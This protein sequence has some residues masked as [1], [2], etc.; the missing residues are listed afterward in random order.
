MKKNVW[1]GKCPKCIAIYI[2][3]SPFIRPKEL[4]AIFKKDL[5]NDRS[6]W[7]H[8]MAL[9]GRS[10]AKPFECV[11]TKEETLVALGLTLQRYRAAKKPLPVI[12]RLF[13][14]EA[15]PGKIDTEKRANA[16][17]GAWDPKN[18]LPREMKAILRNAL[19]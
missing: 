16:I 14:K 2:L 15:Y 4:A 3:L 17:L 10:A 7:P 5:L 18:F 9:L 11:G 6:L 12:L 8:V 19:K 1:C 13:E